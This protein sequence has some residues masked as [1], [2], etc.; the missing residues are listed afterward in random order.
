M[1]V[2]GNTATVTFKHVTEEGLR[3]FETKDV[4]GFTIAGEDQ[5][6]HPATAEI[7][8][9]QPNQVNLFSE[10]VPRPLAV[11][12]A[13]TSNPDCNLYDAEGLPV[14]PFRTDEW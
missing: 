8:R 10:E 9:E 12:Y 4:K 11:R 13:W 3:A 6:F 7:V 1:E 5:V 14:T 2:K